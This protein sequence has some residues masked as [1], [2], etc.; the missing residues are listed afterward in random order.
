MERST[1]IPSP[2]AGPDSSRIAL[3][4]HAISTRKDLAAGVDAEAGL[5]L[6]DRTD[7]AFGVVS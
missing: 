2:I 5:N 1:F 3:S 7:F 6:V 4:T